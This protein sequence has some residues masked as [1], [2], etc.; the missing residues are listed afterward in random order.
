MAGNDHFR[1]LAESGHWISVLHSAMSQTGVHSEHIM[2]ECVCPSLPGRWIERL[3][4]YHRVHPHVQGGGVQEGWS[5]TG[6]LRRVFGV[7]LCV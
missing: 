5:E 1:N 6:V 2:V 7:H 3:F 4:L